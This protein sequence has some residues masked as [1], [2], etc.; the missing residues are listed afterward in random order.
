MID[1]GGKMDHGICCSLLVF[2]IIFTVDRMNHPEFPDGSLLLK[3]EGSIFIWQY[4]EHSLNRDH[5]NDKTI[6]KV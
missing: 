1:G 3:C 4:T 2:L 6:S 5:T